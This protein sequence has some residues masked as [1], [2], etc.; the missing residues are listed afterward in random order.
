MEQISE[1]EDQERWKEAK[2]KEEEILEQVKQF[3]Q[4]EIIMDFTRAAREEEKR[5]SEEKQR[6]VMKRTLKE[7]ETAPPTLPVMEGLQITGPPI[8]LPSTHPQFVTPDPSNFS[9]QGDSCQLRTP[10]KN[11]SEF[12]KARKKAKSKL[13]MIIEE[14]GNNVEIGSDPSDPSD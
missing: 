9:L 11:T 8:T 12:F 5:I 3:Q 1:T 7:M 2:E 14:F 6:E 10:G 4:T 13:P